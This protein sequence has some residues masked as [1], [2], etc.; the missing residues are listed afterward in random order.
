MAVYCVPREDEDLF[1]D[2][3]DAK[4]LFLAGCPSCANI[5]YYLH[6]DNYRPIFKFTLKGIKSVCIQDE[7]DR[8]SLLFKE[9]NMTV[10]SWLPNYPNSMCLSDE[11]ARKK[12]VNKGQDADTILAMCCESGQKHLAKIFP[13]KKLAGAM[14]AKGFLR[15]TTRRKLG[16]FFIDEQSIDILRYT[17][18]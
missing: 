11:G 12:L 17:Q 14:I 5:G 8:I 4:Q 9:K 6:R 16:K 1:S 13:D 7:I 10:A 18:G 15:G 3:G 2:I